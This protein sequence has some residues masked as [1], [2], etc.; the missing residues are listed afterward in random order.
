MS[1]YSIAVATAHGAR[2]MPRKSDARKRMRLM[3]WYW[4][5]VVMRRK[6]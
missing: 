4:N 2:S 5:K 6:P 1:P 3:L